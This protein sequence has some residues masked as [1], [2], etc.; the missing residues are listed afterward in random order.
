VHHLGPRAWRSGPYGDPYS[1]V[2]AIEHHPTPAWQVD[3]ARPEEERGPSV[4]LVVRALW[5]GDGSLTGKPPGAGEQMLRDYD[6][7]GGWRLH[8]FSD[9]APVEP[10]PGQPLMRSVPSHGA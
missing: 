6:A 7:Q 10:F 4:T 1:V 2:E 8:F 5:P 9:H 3:P